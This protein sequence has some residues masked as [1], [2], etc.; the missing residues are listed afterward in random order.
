MEAAGGILTQIWLR[1]WRRDSS[2]CWRKVQRIHH[3]DVG[4]PDTAGEQ[5]LVLPTDLMVLPCLAWDW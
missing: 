2:E 1:R 5:C 4:T 3:R